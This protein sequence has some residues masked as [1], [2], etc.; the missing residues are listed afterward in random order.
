MPIWTYSESLSLSLSL[1]L[2]F[3]KWGSNKDT[4][5]KAASWATLQRGAFGIKRFALN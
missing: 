4:R 1:F 2:S 5:D 3:S